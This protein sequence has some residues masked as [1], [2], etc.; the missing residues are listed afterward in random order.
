MYEMSFAAGEPQEDRVHVELSAVFEKDGKTTKVK[1]FYAGNGSYRLRFLPLEAGTYTYRVTGKLPDGSAEGF[2]RIGEQGSVTAEPAIKGACSLVRAAGTRFVCADGSRFQPFGTTVYALI[3]QGRERL[4]ETFET[5]RQSPFNKL[6]FCLFPKHFEFN[7]NEP[8]L[9]AF[10]KEGDGWNTRK[11]AP[12]YWELLDDT[13][14]RL[15]E[16]EI[17]ADL[18]LFHPY[19]RWGF[20]ALTG[21]QRLDYL[22]YL[23]RRLGAYPNIW[24]SLANEYDQLDYITKEEW[25]GMSAF[26]AAEDLAGHLISNHNFVTPWDFSDPNTTHVCL[27]ES[28]AAKIPGLMERYHKPVVYDEMGYE[29][30]IPDNWGNL[31]AFEMV[32]RFW[33]TVTMG[34]YATHGE[35]YMERM[36]PDQVLWWSKG[37]RLKGE[38]PARIAFLRNLL[39]E[40]PG[41][42]VWS[43]PEGLPKSREEL[44]TLIDAG[45]PGISDNPVMRCM[46]KMT[47]A[48]FEH[49]RQFFRQATLHCG[50]DA[51]LT[52]LGDACTIYH[53]LNLPEDKSYRVEVIDVWE[54]TRTTVQRGAS[55]RA[56]VTL[57]GKPGIAV[58]AVAE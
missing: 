6:R 18:I 41:D 37:G 55:G 14:K 44:Q 29:G 51:Y 54:M 53:L 2:W 52:Y 23:C 33:K 58:L 7:H 32:N 1:E 8:E 19:D 24:W 34:G 57:P 39:E 22:E 28:D 26:L 30:N 11:P 46:A 38:S 15:G 3:H 20:A 21:E 40:L 47:E 35:T 12:A 4:E 5:L 16:L 10:E 31:S 49:M 36:D 48:E 42:M 45:T 27:Q 56:E 13:I 25:L 43:E 50:T 9:F 17:Q